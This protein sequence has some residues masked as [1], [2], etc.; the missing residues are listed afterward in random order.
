MSADAKID[1]YL[2]NFY[3]RRVFEDLLAREE[4]V[5][6]RTVSIGNFIQVSLSK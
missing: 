1:K 3:L 4:N 5:G 2:E 6:A